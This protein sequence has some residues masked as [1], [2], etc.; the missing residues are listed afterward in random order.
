MT[1]YN[2]WKLWLLFGGVVLG[3]LIGILIWR[4]LTA[5]ASVCSPRSN[6]L[7]QFRK[8][9]TTWT[10]NRNTSFSL[11]SSLSQ[12]QPNDFHKLIDLEEFGLLMNQKDCHDAEQKDPLVLIL[13]HSATANWRKRYVI[14]ETW[15]KKDPRAMLLFL[16]G[17][18]NAEDL[19][20]QLSQENDLF[21]DMVQGNFYDAYRNMT[22]KHVMAL[23]WFSYFC[24]S[25]KFLLKTDDDVFINT[26][27]LF[28]H[29]EQGVISQQNL[30]LCNKLENSPVYRKDWSKWCVTTEEYS[31]S[32]YPTYC[33]GFSILY[34]ADTVFRLYEEAQKA[35]YFWIDDV[36]VTGTLAQV[37]NL[38]ITPFGDLYIN[39][40]GQ[41]NGCIHFK[42]NA[43]ISKFLFISFDLT[44]NEVRM[45]WKRVFGK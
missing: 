45:L 31:N 9:R 41:E 33:A 18:V 8:W 15:G 22:Y 30:I 35:S 17:D 4:I 44:E 19:Q 37:A 20:L 29:L 26:P 24:S 10:G 13:V 16:L 21:Q 42:E 23:K 36:H 32:F 43:E 34:S 5:N 11:P 7:T 40:K 39:C 1:K 25:A 2:T 14:R 38:T 27:L 28:Q 12:L 3:L 6:E